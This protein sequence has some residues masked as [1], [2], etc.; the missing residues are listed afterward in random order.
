MVSTKM[1]S[2]NIESVSGKFYMSSKREGMN[3]GVMEMVKCSNL[4]WSGHI[5]RM[6]ESEVTR[7]CKSKV[8]AR[9]VRKDPL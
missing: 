8:D 4:R 2:G 5:K 6:D 7:I 9:G 3:H 1:N